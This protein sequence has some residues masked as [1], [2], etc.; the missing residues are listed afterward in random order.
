[1]KILSSLYRAFKRRV[2]DIHRFFAL[3]RRDGAAY[4]RLLENR[5]CFPPSEGSR[6]YSRLPYKVGI[7][8]DRFIYDG[9]KDTCELKYITPDQS[10]SDLEG[11]DLLLIVS[12]WQGL[13]GEWKG[14]AWSNSP[15]QQR[16]LELMRTA[17][18]MNILTAF[19]SK[20]DPPNYHVFLPFAKEAEIIFTSAEECIERYRRECG[21]D[22]VYLLTF[23]VNPRL[24]N[25]IGMYSP[26]RERDA[27][28]FAGSWIKKYPQRLREQKMLFQLITKS[29]LKLHILDRNDNRG[30]LTYEYPLHWQRYVMPAVE[31]D[32]LPYIYKQHGWILNLNSVYDSRTMFSMRAYDALACGCLVISNPSEGMELTL[33]EVL[34][35]RGEE[36]FDIAT[37]MRDEEKEALRLAG[38]SRVM[39]GHTT[40]D[41]MEYILKKCGIPVRPTKRTVAVIAAQGGDTA[42]L[43][44]QFEAQS[45]PDKIFLTMDEAAKRS[46]EYDAFAFWG[47]GASYG[48]YYLEDM[49][50]AFKYT[51]CRY[52][53]VKIGEGHTYTDTAGDIYKT[54]F[55]NGCFS[56]DEAKNLPRLG[57]SAGGGY[58]VPINYS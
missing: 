3:R 8:A 47:G 50:N 21:H 17:R 49:M 7:V 39:N 30:E 42:R 11:L 57:A 34:V 53:T 45:Y 6:F 35:I 55:W 15:K 33:P 52:V 9:Y 23:A 32:D 16:L 43:R 26:A 1:M 56:A 46:G 19:Y 37:A 44:A 31:Y 27:V 4:E 54:V 41:R 24:Y 48:A 38:I 2:Y 22:R 14:A 13:S 58:V 5:G 18:S 12:S 36:D 51:S 29:G 10:E 25:P 28:L 20:E 40:Y